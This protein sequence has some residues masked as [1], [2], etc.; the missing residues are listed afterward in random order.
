MIHSYSK[1]I[2]DI[3]RS[4]SERGLNVDI[5]TTEARPTAEGM[6]TNGARVAA[7]CKELDLQCSIIPDSA[8]AVHMPDVDCVL[9]GCEAVLANGGIVNKVG[10]YS[11]SLIAGHF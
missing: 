1:V 5:I 4:L 2:L 10:T 3:L 7:R 6:Q 11:V 9:L 8:V